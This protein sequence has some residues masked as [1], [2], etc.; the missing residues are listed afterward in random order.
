MEETGREKGFAGKVILGGDFKGKSWAQNEE[1]EDRR[2][3]L[4]LVV[5][6]VGNR[7][8]FVRRDQKSILD[9][10]MVSEERKDRIRNWRVLEEE[11]TEPS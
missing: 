11:E 9:I 5:A 8:T 6:N 7:P 10:T 4:G 2:G 3:A 1:R